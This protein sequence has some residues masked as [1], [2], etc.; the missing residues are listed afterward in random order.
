[1]F[2]SQDSLRLL[3]H[4]AQILSSAV[5]SCGWCSFAVGRIVVVSLPVG[6]IPAD[7]SPVLPVRESRAESGLLSWALLS[8]V[9][10]SGLCVLDS[11]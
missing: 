2:K 9:V 10:L 6:N 1:M 7:A 8:H 11:K 3:G 5:S 4:R